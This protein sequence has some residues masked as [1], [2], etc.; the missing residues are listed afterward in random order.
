MVI[1]FLFDSF[2]RCMLICMAFLKRLYQLISIVPLMFL[3]AKSGRVSFC[4]FAEKQ[5]DMMEKNSNMNVLYL[6]I[7][8]QR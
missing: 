8:A 3:T 2:E 4:A 1:K 7:D 6:F 5:K